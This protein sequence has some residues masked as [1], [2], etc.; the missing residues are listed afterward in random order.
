[1]MVAGAAAAWTRHTE[2]MDTPGFAGPTHDA[3]ECWIDPG[4]SWQISLR[5][6]VDL[7]AGAMRPQCCRFCGG[8]DRSGV[9]TGV[10]SLRQ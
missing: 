1:M 9:S 10:R 6:A 3:K 5:F 2:P 8:A 7:S 4:T